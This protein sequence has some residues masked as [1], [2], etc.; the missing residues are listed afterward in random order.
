[1]RFFFYIRRM[2][3]LF[4]SIKKIYEDNDYKARASLATFG[5]VVTGF[6]TIVMFII[7]LKF[8]HGLTIGGFIGLLIT[9]ILIHRVVIL[10]RT[11]KEHE[12]LT[13]REAG[14]LK[15]LAIEHNLDPESYKKLEGSATPVQMPSP[16]TVVLPKNSKKVETAPP[17][18]VEIKDALNNSITFTESKKAKVV[19]LGDSI[20]LLGY[21]PLVSE[22]LGDEYEV[23]Q[24]EE[25]GK[26]ASNLLRQLFDYNDKIESADIVHFNA[27]EWDVCDLFGDG[28]FTPKELYVRQIKRVAQLLI[29]KEKKVIFATTTPVGKA[30]VY[31]K[32]EVIAEYNDAVIP[33]LMSM[34][35]RINDLYSVVSENLR[36]N[37]AQ[38]SLHLSDEGAVQCA[39]STARMIKF[40]K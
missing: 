20:R 7:A 26:F 17:T 31:N 19:L 30:N 4:T 40:L 1:M 11:F 13:G 35:V 3:R 27:G 18:D 32:N 8:S 22:Y 28:P 6:Y 39:Q 25:N 15:A 29:N 9:A 2:T 16:G 24:P 36:Q 23:W 5:A 34:G 10:K 14:I 38:D 33:E 37:I 21:G 12:Y